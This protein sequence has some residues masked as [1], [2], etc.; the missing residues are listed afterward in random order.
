MQDAEGA[1]LWLVSHAGPSL[2]A[3]SVGQVTAPRT[4]WHVTVAVVETRGP[5][6]SSAFG[7][8]QSL[9]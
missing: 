5:N 8:R 4:R 3:E 7:T 1:V 2:L 9:R 6:V